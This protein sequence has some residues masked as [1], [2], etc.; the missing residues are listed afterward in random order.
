MDGLSVL[1]NREECRIVREEGKMEHHILIVDDEPNVI[2]SLKRAL[3][4][5]PYEVHTA[6]GGAEGLGIL[7]THPVKVVISDERMP[8]MSGAEF[9]CSVKDRYPETV[10]MM[11]TGHASIESAMR[12][13][14]AG[15]IY[16]F[17]T[18]PWDDTELRLAIRSAVEKFDLEEEN[19]RLLRIV[20]QQALDLKMLERR[21][22]T[23]TKL[24][25]DEQGNLMIL[26]ISDDEFS[27][28]VSQCERDFR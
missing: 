24:D 9:L 1:R 12:A 13:V 10:R 19:R 4:D 11:L 14:N 7:G 27:E 20:R 22:P 21:Y 17:F 8:G 6:P 3:M 28:I 5:D 15:E 16:R 18:K 23:I 25:R 2:A 26:E